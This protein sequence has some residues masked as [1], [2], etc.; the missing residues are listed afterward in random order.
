MAA[1][2]E[3]VVADVGYVED[4]KTYALCETTIDYDD[5]ESEMASKYVAG[6]TILNFLWQA[7]EAA[8]AGTVLLELPKLLKE[9]RLGERGRRLFETRP[10]VSTRFSGL[11][12]IIWLAFF[13]CEHGGLF[14]ARLA[15]LRERFNDRNL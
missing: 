3:D 9:G 12:K 4:P 6:A 14:K 10:E 8:V 15:R 11:G 13:Q 2:I 7:Y 1:S 5:T